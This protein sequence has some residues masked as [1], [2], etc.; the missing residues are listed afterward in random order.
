ML[1]ARGAPLAP[2]SGTTPKVEQELFLVHRD[3]FS[4]QLH[5]ILIFVPPSRRQLHSNVQVDH[6]HLW[7]ASFILSGQVTVDASLGSD[8]EGKSGAELMR[9]SPEGICARRGDSSLARCG[10]LAIIANGPQVEKEARYEPVS[11]LRQHESGRGQ[12]RGHIRRLQTPFRIRG[13]IHPRRRKCNEA[14]SG[15]AAD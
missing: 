11:R 8:P 5:V 6:L 4:I 1:T 10:G 7:D 12:Q 13:D 2:R 15:K 14:H 3:D 9:S